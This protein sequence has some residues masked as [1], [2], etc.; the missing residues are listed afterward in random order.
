MN[1][2]NCFDPALITVDLQERLVPSVYNPD[3]VVSRA[4]V[5]LKGAAELGVPVIATEQYPKGL[6]NTIPAIAELFV[7]EKTVVV[8]KTSFSVFGEEKFREELA[9]L[10]PHTLIFCGIETHVCVL[11]SVFNALEAGYP[12]IIAADAVSSRKESEKLLALETARQ[13][14]AW[15]LS[16]ESILF[17]LLKNSLHPSFKAVSKLIK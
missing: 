5:L 17:M 11:H 14:G 16:T 10:S 13:A 2:P 4:T 3:E 7:P 6:G 9:N 1:L 8:A 15:L 12:V